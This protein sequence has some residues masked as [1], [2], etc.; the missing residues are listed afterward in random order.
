MNNIKTQLP[1]LQACNICKS[2]SENGQTLEILM[3]INLQIQAGECVALT[4]VSGS[5][6]STLLHIL[7][8]LD[9]SD[10]GEIY[11]NGE[12]MHALSLDARAG[13]RNRSLGFVYQ[14]HHLLPEFSAR[15]NTAMPLLIRGISKKEAYAKAEYFLAKV[16]LDQRFSHRPGELSGGERQRVAIARSLVTRPACALMDEP[17]GNLDEYTAKKTHDLMLE[18]NQE[19]GISLLIVTHNNTLANSMKRVLRLHNGVLENFAP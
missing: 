3:N 7:G 10:S 12:A 14:F 16:G 11:V 9:D 15:E 19:F 8:G 5:G 4:G 17:T 13:L 6:K 2:Y 1:A 18:L